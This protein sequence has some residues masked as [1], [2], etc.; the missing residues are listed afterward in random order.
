MIPTGQSRGD[1]VA[2]VLFD[3]ATKIVTKDQEIWSLFP[4]IGRKF[5]GMFIEY[6]AIFLDTPGLRISNAIL[7][8][9]DLLRRH[10]AMSHAK[11]A[12]G[13]LWRVRVRR[14]A[15]CGCSDGLV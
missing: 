5:F 2:D 1:S 13:K 11:A 7:E 4:G 8:N 6:N 9:D 14:L 15:S 12:C 3:L 10:V